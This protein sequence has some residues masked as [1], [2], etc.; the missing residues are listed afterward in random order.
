MKEMELHWKKKLLF[1]GV[2]MQENRLHAI[3]DRNLNGMTTKQ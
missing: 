1:S 2:F 3:Q